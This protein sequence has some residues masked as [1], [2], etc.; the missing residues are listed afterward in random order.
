VDVTVVTPGGTSATSAADKFILCG[1]STGTDRY[2][3]QSDASG[4]TAGGT[5]VTVTGSGFFGGGSS[6]AVSKV[7]FGTTAG[8]GLNRYFGHVS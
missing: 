8:T 4:T 6:S 2:E 3:H 1:A 5:T 7:N